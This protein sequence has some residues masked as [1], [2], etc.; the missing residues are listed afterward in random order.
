MPSPCTAFDSLRVLQAK[1][2]PYAYYALH[3]LGALGYTQLERLPY[4]IRVLVENALRAHALGQAD[5]D[6]VHAL[7]GWRPRQ[8]RRQAVRF[9][10]TRI[11]MQDFT[12]VPAL[13][14]LAALRDAVAARGED[15][16]RVEPQVPVDLVI[17]HSV[18]IEHVGVPD[19]LR[20]NMAREFERNG[21]RYRFLRW[22][23]GAFENL[24][25]VPPGSGICHQ[26]NLEHL[27]TVVSNDG[28]AM[29]SAAIPLLY[30]DSLVGTDS[31][32]TM[33][34]ALG[35]LGWGVGGLEAEAAM[36]GRALEVQL[37]DVVG[38]RLHG[39]PAEGTSA[40]DL[41]L[42]L[43]QRLRKEGVVGSFVEFLG[44]GL[45]LLSLPDR[46]TLANMAPEY[47]A[48]CAYF[49]IDGETLRY[50]ASTGR[51]E[52]QV[53][54]V[55][56]Y[57]RAQRLWRDGNTPEPSYSRVV[58]LDLGEVEPCLAGP[59]RPQDRTAVSDLEDSFE[60]AF[61]IADLG[62]R[63]F[64]VA[65]EPYAVGDGSIVLA[66]ITSCTN[67]SNPA[68][69]IAAGL[70]AQKAVRR[71]LK[72]KPWVMTS[73]APGSTVVSDYLQRLGL[74]DS[75]N[76]L[77]FDVA[78]YGCA[79]CVG[80][81]APLAAD[82][83]KTVADN[84]LA[85]AAV[86]S[87]NRNFEAR[88]NPLIKANYLASPAL[89]VAYALAG[90]LRLDL[91]RDPIDMDENAEPVFLRDIWPSRTT[92]DAAMTDAIRPTMF[93]AR[94]KRLF[95]GPPDWKALPV[96]AGATYDWDDDS[97]YVR[98]PPFLNLAGARA[99]VPERID[100]ARI[101]LLLGDGVTTDHISPAGPISGEG[102]AAEYLTN[103]GVGTDDFNAF[104]ARR[105]NHEVMIRGAFANPRLRNEMLPERLG[106]F[107]RVFPED[108]EMS[109]FD[110]AKRYRRTKTP[111]VIVAGKDY[112]GGSS[113]DWAAKGTA[114]LGVKAVIAESFERIHRS[115]LI[116]L[117]ILPLQFDD[118]MSRRS[119]ALEGPELLSIT[120]EGGFSPQAIVKLSIRR[121]TTA[122]EQVPLRCR[123][124][125]AG[126]L[127]IFRA[128]GLLPLM[129]TALEGKC[130]SDQRVDAPLPQSA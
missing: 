121:D 24:R 6:D 83:A 42:M 73:F 114:L 55:E 36:L 90:S 30:P 8:Q 59:R 129:L 104:G 12:G 32:T 46:A 63:R 54:M 95:E 11:L 16:S 37:P 62:V 119:L 128:G 122:I 76:R 51:E 23:Q 7:A 120:A 1:S 9:R 126:E 41:V 34:N 47:G 20:R 79:A 110:A 117:G 67:T 98:C 53:A 57:A 49:P 22:A 65:Q 75:L 72:T 27:A 106:G 127:E 123:I 116:A 33:V 103:R 107:T 81:T 40:T 99:D 109:V 52:T 91:L 25:I 130:G 89:V 80:N 68:S 44:H 21:E 19:A 50:L 13:V 71:G 10:P 108:H 43:T 88:I 112:G 64:A 5:F 93:R 113:R 84:D 61:G 18:I 96:P 85:V 39:R 111:L 124:D 100:A 17:D 82:L 35:V 29:G 125:T 101:L 77:G 74:Q 15:A 58:D 70:L 26:V 28:P 97:T 56:A 92:I 60:S 78:A 2:R 69:M 115:N 102:P 31:H 48:T 105:G 3:T 86:L 45:D 4:A 87:G 38:V 94:Y 14:D 118:G 66:A